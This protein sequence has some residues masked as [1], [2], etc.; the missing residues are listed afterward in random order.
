MKRT[1]DYSNDEYVVVKRLLQTKMVTKNVKHVNMNG[2]IGQEGKQ[3][4][5]VELDF[6][7]MSLLPILES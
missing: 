7:E 4:R 1:C 6:D 5:K 3:K 2:N